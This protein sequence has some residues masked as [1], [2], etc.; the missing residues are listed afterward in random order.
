MM[1][2]LADVGVKENRKTLLCKR[3]GG[4]AENRWFD[5][6]E[7]RHYKGRKDGEETKEWVAS[8]WNS[9]CVTGMNG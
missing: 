3:S 1:L 6:S 8:L 2:F 9:G 5:R 7:H 4:D